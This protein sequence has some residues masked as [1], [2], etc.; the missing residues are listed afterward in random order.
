[1]AD[2]NQMS[3]V[4]NNIFDLYGFASVVHISTRNERIFT[5]IVEVPRREQ[6]ADRCIKLYIKHRP[7]F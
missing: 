2:G 4:K 6:V 1:M 7:F 5:Q 3:D